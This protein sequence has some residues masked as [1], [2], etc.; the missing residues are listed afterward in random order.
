MRL[1]SANLDECLTQLLSRQAAWLDQQLAARELLLV[2]YPSQVFLGETMEKTVLA[3]LRQ[4]LQLRIKAETALP[5]AALEMAIAG[6]AVAWVPLSIVRPEQ[7]L[8]I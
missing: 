3:E 4:R 2:A 5:H 1:R 8:T 7:H 6:V